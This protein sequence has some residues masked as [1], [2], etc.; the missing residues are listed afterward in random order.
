M[1]KN[2]KKNKNVNNDTDENM[3]KMNINWDIGKYIKP[4]ANISK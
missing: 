2:N 4:I 1:I 3:S